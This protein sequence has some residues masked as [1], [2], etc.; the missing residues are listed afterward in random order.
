LYTDKADLVDVRE[1]KKAAHR[2]AGQLGGKPEEAERLLETEWKAALNRRAAEAQANHDAAASPGLVPRVEVLDQAPLAVRRPLS[3]VDGHAYAAAWPHVQVTR[4]QTINPKTG[5]VVNH[6]PPLVQVEPVLVIVRNDGAIFTIEAGLVGAGLGQEA[7]PLARLGVA[8]CL[9]HLPPPDRV[10]SGAGLKR[11]L[12]GERAQPADVFGRVAAVVDRFLDFTRSLAGQETMCQLTA[13]YVLAT[14]L[15]DAFHVIGYLWSSG[16]WGAAKTKYIHVVSELAYLGRLILA[17]STYATLRDEADYGATLAFDDAEG[18]TDPRRTDPDKRTLLL[19]GNRKGAT[20]AL[21][22]LRGDEWVTRYISTFCPR[23]FSAIAIPDDVL[24][25][26]AILV[27]M[28]K[29]DDKERAEASPDDYSVW[30]SDRRRLLD[31]LWAL[32]LE[33]L[34]ALP[35]YDTRAAARSPLIGRTLEPWR[36]ILAVALWLQEG[37]GVE[38][39][40]DRMLQL[41]QDYQQERVGMEG[42]NVAR[43][44]VRALLVMLNEH[45]DLGTEEK[46]LVFTASE[47][48]ERM[49]A[50]A[51][52]GEA[53]P[54]ATSGKFHMTATNGPP[55]DDEEFT[56]SRKVGR[57]LGQLRLQRPVRGRQRGWS[58]TRADIERLARAYGVTAQETA[59]DRAATA[60]QEEE[61]GAATA[62]ASEG[63]GGA[64]ADP[65]DSNYVDL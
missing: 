26:R 53:T 32:G 63:E 48:A 4:A 51:G 58:A 47:L 27:P 52:D 64:A 55:K 25:S 40:F 15:L 6:D 2:L 54:T 57:L 37:H 59:E 46:P 23:L 29:T 24:A 10:W 30:P 14:Y 21:K 39:V 36:A 38:G 20:A 50:L 65:P 18:I 41:A 62:T 12:T 34:P 31:D 3:L 9:P 28:T 44:A 19:A 35:A 56:N 8:V 61:E 11:F 16:D 22:E 1:R 45:P 13:L 42:A 7:Q 43:V 17:G 60:A 49:N 5:T 33:H